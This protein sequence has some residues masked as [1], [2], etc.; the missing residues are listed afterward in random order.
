LDAFDFIQLAS[1]DSTNDE[2]KRRLIAGSLARPTCIVAQQQT[3]GRGTHGRMWAS[4]PG[5][6]LYFTVVH[7]PAND[8]GLPL[9]PWY[10]LVAGLCCAEALQARL[11]CLIQLKP[12]NDLYAQGRKLGGL[13]LESWVQPPT[14]SG[15]A[16]RRIGLLTG[17]G[18]NLLP[19]PQR[20]ALLPH[21][22]A[23]RLGSHGPISLAEFVPGFSSVWD[24]AAW[25]DTFLDLYQTW[26]VRIQRQQQAT[27][28][29]LFPFYNRYLLPGHAPPSL[30]SPG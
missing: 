21:E 22:D 11:G 6:G 4:P 15:K 26:L 30:V 23:S 8:D 5:V 10:P 27:E 29:I 25:L 12:I 2:A 3:A 28:E 14:A 16:P 13:L 20:L 1:V 19:S 18:M 9:W 24:R 7:P 17:V